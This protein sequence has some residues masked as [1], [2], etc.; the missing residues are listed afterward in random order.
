MRE[1]KNGSRLIRLLSLSFFSAQWV[2]RYAGTDVTT[3]TCDAS[4]SRGS[5]VAAE[6]DQTGY[7]YA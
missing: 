2:S 5:C 3:N 1:V 7:S 4:V 6:S